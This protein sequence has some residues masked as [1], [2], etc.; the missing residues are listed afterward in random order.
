[1]LDRQIQYFDNPFRYAIIDNFF[2]KEDLEFVSENIDKVEQDTN[3][4]DMNK[5]NF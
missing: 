1:M 4:K 3:F 2:S 5:L